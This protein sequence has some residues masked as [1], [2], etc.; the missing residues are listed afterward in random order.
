MDEPLAARTVVFPVEDHRV[1][2]GGMQVRLSASNES[3]S[4]NNKARSN[5][6]RSECSLECLTRHGVGEEQ[7][8]RQ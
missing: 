6:I 2:L 7:G 4:V 1:D 5:R 8:Q 3:I